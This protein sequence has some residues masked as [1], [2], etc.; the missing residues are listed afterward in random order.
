VKEGMMRVQSLK[1]IEP[2][3]IL[4]DILS[5]KNF[6]RSADKKAIIIIFYWPFNRK[7]RWKISS[8][9]IKR[10][11]EKG[12]VCNPRSGEHIRAMWTIQFVAH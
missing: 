1:N 9:I 11:I 8:G 10:W 2:Q 12:R 3:S 4:K 7:R 5:L 6:Q